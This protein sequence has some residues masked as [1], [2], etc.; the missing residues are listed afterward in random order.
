MSAAKGPVFVLGCPRSG[1]TV[2]Y[3]M[4]LSAGDFAMYRAESNVFSVMVPRFGNLRSEQNR[5]RLMQYWLQS[6]LFYVSGLD[7][8]EIEARIMRDCR[9]GGDFLRI[10]MESVAAKQGVS[11][12]ADCT[13]DHLLYLDEIRQ[14]IPDARIIHII[15][16]GRDVA[17]SY[18]KQ[19]WSYPMP[20]DRSEHLAVAG[21]YWEWIVR[22]GRYDGRKFGK[23]YTEVRFEDLV[24]SP[25]ETLASLSKFVGQELDYDHIQQV[26]VGSVKEPNSS[27]SSS[28]DDKFNPVGRWRSQYSDEQLAGIEN[29]V[30][31]F[32][33]DLGYPL[34]T[35][36]KKNLR[37][38]RLRGEY[39]PFFSAKRWLKDCTPLGR[40]TSI[41]R[42]EIGEPERSL[43]VSAPGKNQ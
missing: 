37:V 27:F 1:T 32:L 11:R 41:R 42:M 3:H 12:W 26:G 28:G 21:L 31:A 38:A 30:G 17:L 22:R 2:L 19:G 43:Q 10:V 4:L 8:S 39:L 36:P 5:R 20:W 13:P 6:K 7:A 40:Y 34:M 25:R 29:V 16:D 14:Q 15:R 9:S 23:R 24:G 33:E 35:K 18:V